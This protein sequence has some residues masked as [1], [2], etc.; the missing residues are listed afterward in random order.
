MERLAPPDPVHGGDRGGADHLVDRDDPGPL[1]GSEQPG[2]G[3]LVHGE[4]VRDLGDAGDAV[5]SDHL[6][7]RDRHVNRLDGVVPHLSTSI[8]RS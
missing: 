8:A 1:M 5:A 2:H 7:D 6:E 3:G 4:L